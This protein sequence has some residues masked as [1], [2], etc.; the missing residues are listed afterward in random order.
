MLFTGITVSDEAAD[1][2][3]IPPDPSVGVVKFEP[4]A[5]ANAVQSEVS[6]RIEQQF[7]I[8]EVQSNAE[9][10]EDF[11]RLFDRYQVQVLFS[12]HDHSYQRTWRIRNATR[13][14]ADDVRTRRTTKGMRREPAI[15]Q[16]TI[17]S[18]LRVIV[19]AWP[20]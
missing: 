4:G 8:V 2:L 9:F 18:T 1:R 16:P 17:G 7:P 5:D 12:G 15:H 6:D 3:D 10:K 14:R 13:Q 20:I 19:K 11:G